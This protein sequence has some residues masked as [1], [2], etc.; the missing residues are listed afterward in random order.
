VLALPFAFAALSTAFANIPPSLHEAAA[1]EGAGLR[2]RLLA[3]DLPLVLPSFRSA[4]AFSAALSLGEL[5]TPLM[6][7]LEHW[8]TLPLY[9]YRSIAAYRYGPACAAGTLLLAAAWLLFKVSEQGGK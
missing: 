2:Q 6:L 1:L 8:E 7:G 5:N 4:W 3:I 9:I